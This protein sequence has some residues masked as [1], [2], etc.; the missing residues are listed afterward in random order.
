[1]PRTAA[2]GQQPTLALQKQALGIPHF[3]VVFT[4][5]ARIASIAYQNKAVRA[6]EVPQ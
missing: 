2:S 5:P 3:H 6:P 1:L 4:L